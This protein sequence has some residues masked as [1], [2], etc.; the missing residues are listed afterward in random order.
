MLTH[1]S[2]GG[3][4]DSLIAQL[5]ENGFY[6]SI[7]DAIIDIGMSRTKIWKKC[8]DVMSKDQAVFF[9]EVVK[10][11]NAM[12][13]DMGK[14]KRGKII[15]SCCGLPGTGKSFLQQVLHAYC[16]DYDI[17]IQTVA[18]TNYIALQQGGMTLNRAI[19]NFCR[20]VLGVSNYRIDQNLLD[21]FKREWGDEQYQKQSFEHMSIQTLM[22]HIINAGDIRAYERFSPSIF[23]NSKNVKVVLIDEGSLITNVSLA[24]LLCSIPPQYK[25]VYVLF[26]GQ[27]QLPPVSPGYNLSAC[28]KVSWGEFGS[29]K[30]HSLT[31]QQRFKSDEEVNAFNEFVMYFNDNCFQKPT[32]IDALKVKYFVDNIQIGGSLQEYKQLRDNKILIVATNEKRNEENE[33]R[34]KNDGDGRVFSIPAIMDPGI[35]SEFNTYSNLGIDSI[36]KLRKGSI[37]Y[38]RTNRLCDRL[39]KGML[40]TVVDIEEAKDGLG[41][42]E[43]VKSITVST[44]D[45]KITLY[46]ESFKTQYFKDRKKKEPAFVQQFP[47]TLGYAITCHGA[48]GKTFNCNVGINI[49]GYGF[50][51]NDL[52]DNM[53]FVA[54]TR[55]RKP[56]QIYMDNHPALWL[57]DRNCTRDELEE[58]VR[59]RSHGYDDAEEFMESRKKK[60]RRNDICYEDIYQK[61]MRFLP[62]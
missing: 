5:F 13:R 55:V 50:P 7:E 54:I 11:I 14:E 18:P 61:I 9:D 25:V 48:Q 43:F 24:T 29:G 17:D 6:Q 36:L 12:N 32:T 37:C 15:H 59:S 46:R 39:V 44:D 1:E 22:K 38:C 57:L 21:R 56:S 60:M 62:K 20:E 58:I 42:E 4:Y 52:C 45:R 34:L 27:N 35:S 49:D 33:S 23:S 2:K 47:L 51:Q 31:S 53:F 10:S 41:G 8:R 19:G 26:Y 3:I 30:T 16:L 40:L 28:Y